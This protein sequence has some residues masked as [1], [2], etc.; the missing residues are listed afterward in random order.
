[1]IPYHRDCG[2]RYTFREISCAPPREDSCEKKHGCHCRPPCHEYPFPNKPSYPC[3]PNF[4]SEQ[5]PLL[6]KNCCNSN[7][8]MFI[9][10]LFLGSCYFQDFS[11]HQEDC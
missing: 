10:G 3:K 4:P 11:T 5:F 8:N 9:W 2:C 6:P 7:L 1:M